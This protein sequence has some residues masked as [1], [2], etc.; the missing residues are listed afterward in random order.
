MRPEAEG[1]GR[2]DHRELLRG[3]VGRGQVRGDLSWRLG[4]VG[5]WFCPPWTIN[6][7]DV[8]LVPTGHLTR[9]INTARVQETPNSWPE[10]SLSRSG[11]PG[12]WTEG[13]G[14]PESKASG[15]TAHE[16]QGS[17]R[18]SM[19]TD[20]SGKAQSNGGCRE[21]QPQA[22][23]AEHRGPSRRH[24]TNSSAPTGTAGLRGSDRFCMIY[25][26]SFY[27][28]LDTDFL[29]TRSLYNRNVHGMRIC[30]CINIESQKS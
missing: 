10:A 5:A 22:R 12:E 4:W 11:F 9:S 20:Q 2:G 30:R 8:K 19:K 7:A 23:V 17:A 27:E 6:F 3:G 16:H 26:L 18:R 21:G 29:Y 25:T 1:R 24:L 13:S 15:W 14:A 28:H